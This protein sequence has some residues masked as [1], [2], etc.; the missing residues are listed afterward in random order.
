MYKFMP[1]EIWRHV[2]AEAKNFIDQC[3]Q[4]NEELRPTAARA[5]ALPWM[6]LAT[7]AMEEGR[8]ARAEDLG[9]VGSERPST[10]L[11]VSSPPFERSK[12]IMK[13]FRRMNQLSALE[14]ACVITS[15]HCITESN[16]KLLENHSSF[17]QEART[18]ALDH[19][20]GAFQGFEQS[21]R[22]HRGHHDVVENA[23]R[24]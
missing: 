6:Q 11:S 18:R 13:A 23:P 16:I 10:R 24:S 14:K 9:D 3:L 5:L 15:A 4:K 20:T 22:P 17:D 2:S 21:R 7:A 19:C 1:P 12:D 8:I